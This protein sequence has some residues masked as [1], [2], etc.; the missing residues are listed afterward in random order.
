MTKKWFLWVIILCLILV[1]FCFSA[2]GYGKDTGIILKGAGAT[3]PHPLYKE[4]MKVYKTETGIRTSYQAI[5]SGG[6]I[7]AL[8][9]REVD[10]GAT[11][12]FLSDEE[13]KKNENEILHIP[14]CLGAVVIIYNLPGKPGLKL[15]PRLVADIFQGKITR[16]SDKLIQKVNQGVNIPDLEIAVVHRSDSSGTTF[17]FTNY[18]STI[19]AQWKEKIGAGKLVRWPTGIGVERNPGVANFVKKVPGAIGYVELT[20]A[21]HVGLPTAMIQ[22]RSGHFIKP[23]L[24]AVNHAARVSL[25]ADTRTLIINTPASRGY[26]ISAFT[27][28][29]FYKEQSYYNRTLKRAQTLA[30][31]LWWA[32][33]DG[34]RYNNKNIYGTLPPEA[35]QKAENIIRSMVFN[36]KPVVDW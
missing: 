36:G 26:P 25:P 16:W 10:F 4:W 23:T 31:Y 17:I 28:L 5:G 22:N 33:H 3:F 19:S 35:I 30:R 34:Q 15:T 13:L 12:A 29:I 11:D 18:L 21:V 6:G 1:L 14:T 2:E 32:I 27:W 20:Y 24:E 9:N 8:L 7:K